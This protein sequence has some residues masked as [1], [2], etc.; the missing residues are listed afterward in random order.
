MPKS[1]VFFLLLLSYSRIQAQSTGVF[2]QQYFRNPLGIPIELS[3]NFGEVRK[4]HFHMGLDIRTRQR[5]NLPVYAAADGYITRIS[6]QRYGYGK[7]IYIQ[8][9]DGYTTVYGHLNGF[10]DTLDHYIVQK[11]YKEEQWE[12]DFSLPAGQF[13]VA[14]GQ[15]I[16]WSGNTGSSGGP[17]LHFEIRESRTGNNLNP[18]LFGMG[19]TDDIAPVLH[20]LYWYDRRY[21]TYQGGAKRI[22]VTGAKGSYTV[23]GGDTVR[24]G[25]PRISFAVRAE[26]RTN[27]SS[28]LFGIYE[29]ALW[30]DDSLR[31]NFQI[32]NF[33][34]PDS[35]YVN[36]SIDYNVFQ[37]TG[38]GIQHLSQLPGNRLSVYSTD[39]ARG[40]I[41]FTDTLPHTVR[42]LLRD[43][44]GNSTVVQFAVKYD[45]APEENLFFTMNSVAVPP[46]KA[47]QIKEQQVDA[48]F[49]ESAFYD[50]VPFVLSEQPWRSWP[51]GSSAVGLHNATIPVHDNYTVQLPLRSDMN[52]YADRLLMQLES[53]RYKLVQKARPAAPGWYKAGFNRLGTV[54]LIAD[55]IAPTIATYGWK[56]GQVFT[57][58]TNLHVR[59]SDNQG[60]VQ[61]FRALLDGQWLLFTHSTSDYIYTFD[62]HCGIGS[63][64]ITVSVQDV[65]GNTT[66][67]EFQFTK[68]APN[69]GSNKR[70]K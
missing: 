34:Y 59:C 58:Q 6:I 26:D 15:F 70:R 31:C 39:K 30:L 14:K 17:H 28:F 13:P 23:N 66:I 48:S 1:V 60:E 9:P 4:D 63:H 42:M 5:V 54:Q 16:A 2:P 3:A 41:S 38:Q 25:S 35:R 36:G 37:Q 24:I 46:A 18:L 33:T 64:I 43:V 44:S 20:G 45:P 52:A 56:N 7:A 19:V 32:N 53:G 29:A 62:E 22:P 27:S 57:N 50:T 47:H 51:A 67:K 12:Q 65:A 49:S 10:Y 21:S 40:I 68:K 55:T 61:Q 69:N 11:Q 8:H